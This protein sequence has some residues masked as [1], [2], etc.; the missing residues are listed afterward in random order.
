MLS[1]TATDLS[2]HYAKISEAIKVCNQPV[3]ITKNG[4]VDMI[5]MSPL[6]F[7]T[8]LESIENLEDQCLIHQRSEDL[9]NISFLEFDLSS[10]DRGLFK[11]M[12]IDELLS[13]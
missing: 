5:A 13:L 3:F 6:C 12:D 2:N 4:K 11:D 7:E 9:T 10:E 1:F 8:L